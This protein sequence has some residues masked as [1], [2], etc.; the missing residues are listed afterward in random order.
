MRKNETQHG[1]SSETNDYLLQS[2]PQ[3]MDAS[4]IIKFN[5]VDN[6]DD[7]Y[8]KDELLHG[9][10]ACGIEKPSAIQ[11]LTILTCIKGLDVIV[12]AQR[13]TGKITSVLISICQQIDTSLN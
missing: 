9:I 1:Q 10:H 3:S 6:F 4:G 8:L 2:E 13:G 7:M 12:Q 5:V 11:R